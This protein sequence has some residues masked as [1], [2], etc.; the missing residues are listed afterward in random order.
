M[1]CHRCQIP[2]SV[3]RVECA[4]LHLIKSWGCFYLVNIRLIVRT[5][6]IEPVAVFAQHTTVHVCA[7]LKRWKCPGLMYA[8]SV[9]CVSSAAVAVCRGEGRLR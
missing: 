9:G 7:H 4:L 2:F 3:P 8:H 6:T 5:I 1:S